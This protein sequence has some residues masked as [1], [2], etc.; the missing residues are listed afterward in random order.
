MPVGREEI[1]RVRVQNT[2]LTTL[3]PRTADRLSY[4]WHQTDGSAAGEEG[5][6]SELPGDLPPGTSATVALRVAGP[7]RTG[8]HVLEL[9]LVREHVAWAP[10]PAGL[11][12][13][14]V[15]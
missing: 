13:T 6:R 9:G 3:S 14:A 11:P 10:A 4:R 7:P 12:N 15:V 2:G 1:L 8:A 5:L